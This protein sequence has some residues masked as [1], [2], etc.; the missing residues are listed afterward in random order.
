MPFTTV[1][2]RDG[3]A[4]AYES[5]GEGQPVILVGGAFND[6]RA[7]AAGLPL[8]AL[9]ADSA[10]AVA[11][12]RR[13]RGDSTTGTTYSVEN[14]IDDLSAL[15]S[16]FDK[17]PVLFGHSSGAALALEAVASGLAVTAVAI[18]DPP[19]VETQEES[20]IG[21][22]AAAEIEGY[23]QQGRNGDAAA[24]FLEWIGMPAARIAGM[25][26]A[27]MWP[28]M[29]RLAPTLVHENTIVRRNGDAFPPVAKVARITAPLLAMAGSNSPSSMR[30][31]ARNLASA[32]P[33]GQYEELAGLD[34]SAP[35]EAI[36]KPLLSFLARL[37]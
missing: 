16:A 10:F 15:A 7:P 22:A 8:A 17:P 12:D 34:H 14:E 28:G 31:A 26:M 30:T 13:G 3:A 1:T 23:V 5:R 29:E 25:R 19:Y 20:E 4:I 35:A 36:A 9:L 11:Y 6:R 32:A 18:F 37:R 21:A 27:P 2:S 24:R 33:V